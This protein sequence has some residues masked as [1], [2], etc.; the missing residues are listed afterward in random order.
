MLRKSKHS[1]KKP[2]N[3]Q[4]CNFVFQSNSNDNNRPWNSIE[5]RLLNIGVWCLE[6]I[7]IYNNY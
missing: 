6:L 2:N 1:G 4:N 5:T 3:K 7:I